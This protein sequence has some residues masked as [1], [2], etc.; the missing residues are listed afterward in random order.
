MAN[1]SQYEFTHQASWKPLLDGMDAEK[2]SAEL[3]AYPKLAVA[4]DVMTQSLIG[5][6]T[7]HLPP[8]NGAPSKVKAPSRR[9]KKQPAKPSRKKAKKKAR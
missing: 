9:A 3:E 7:P 5:I 4:M 6:M 2:V 8:E 1:A